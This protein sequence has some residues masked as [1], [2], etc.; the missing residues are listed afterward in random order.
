MLDALKN[1]GNLPG[2]MAKAREMQ[3]KMQAAQAELGRQQFTADAAG[4]AVTAIVNGR[5]ELVKIRIDKTK[6]NPADTELLEDLTVAAVAAAQ[7]KAT[8][9]I[10]Q[11]MS[12]VSSDLGLPPGSIPGM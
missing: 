2:L 6:I 10:Q 1:L 9:G 7:A 11:H 12:K 5:L 3:E 4:G 8:A